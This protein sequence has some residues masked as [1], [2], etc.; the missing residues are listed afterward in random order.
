MIKSTQLGFVRHAPQDVN[1]LD[2][3]YPKGTYVQVPNLSPGN[4][5]CW[6]KQEARPRK[7]IIIIGEPKKSDYNRM[8]EGADLISAYFAEEFGLNPRADIQV[9]PQ[10]QHADIEK[11]IDEVAKVGSQGEYAIVV[12]GHGEAKIPASWHVSLENQFKQG[13]KEGSVK[14]G[15]NNHLN[16]LAT[17]TDLTKLASMHSGAL[18]VFCCNSSAWLAQASPPQNSPTERLPL[19]LAKN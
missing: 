6:D 7:L 19:L 11:A 14:L 17:K 18:L 1:F 3:Q 2:C 5:T 10:P 16:E 13:G 9:L 4:V 15:E 12:I 8:T